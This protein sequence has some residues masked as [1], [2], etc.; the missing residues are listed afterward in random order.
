[1]GR[2]TAVQLSEGDERD[3]LAFLRND[4]D[5]R[6]L[7]WTAPTP[8]EIFIPEFLPRGPHHHHFRLWNT[9]FPWTPEFAQHGPERADGAGSH[10]YLV[11][12]AGAPVIEYVREPFEN[13]K[14]II[15]GRV[16]WNTDLA[17]YRG[18]PYDVEAFNRWFSKL[19]RWLRK[20]GRRV[21]I[22]KTWYQYWLPGAWRLRTGS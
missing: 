16:Y 10:F 1:M 3:F 22:T 6:V 19:V 11:N 4:A 5:V 15:H 18:T 21:E 17:I 8:E 13:P 14:S 20:K 9:A 12:T 2:Q 7:N